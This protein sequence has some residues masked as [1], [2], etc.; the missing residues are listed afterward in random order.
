[1]KLTK[2]TAM[3]PLQY[4]MF[5]Q[6]LAAKWLIYLNMGVRPTFWN[7]LAG[8]QK[9]TLYDEIA[10]RTGKDLTRMTNREIEKYLDGLIPHPAQ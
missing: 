3:T 4:R 5:I 6:S 7:K 8:T 1:M 2:N 9:D 10:R